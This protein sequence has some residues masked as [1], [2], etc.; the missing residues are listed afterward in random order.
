MLSLHNFI[1]Y[2]IQYSSVPYGGEKK[3]VHAVKIGSLIKVH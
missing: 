2:D 1:K 3:N